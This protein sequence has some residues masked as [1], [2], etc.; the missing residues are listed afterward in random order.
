MAY[1]YKPDD[2]EPVVTGSGS[3]VASNLIWAITVLAIVGA[4][5]WVVFFSGALDNLSRPAKQK[6]DV[7]IS[8]PRR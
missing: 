3:N 8:V 2:D 5:I 7:N 1:V 4:I 6:V